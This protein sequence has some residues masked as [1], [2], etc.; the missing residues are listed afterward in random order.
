MKTI[1][2]SFA[3]LGLAIAS[4][5]NS[6]KVTLFQPSIV[7]GQEL[8]PGTYKVEVKDTTAVISKGKQSVEAPIKSEAGDSKFASTTVRY[9][10]DS[11]RRYHHEDRVRQLSPCWRLDRRVTIWAY[12]VSAG[13]GIRVPVRRSIVRR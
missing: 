5:A 1:L 7:A 13:R 11:V 12:E 4:G 9:R 8:Q 6:Y 3:T 2:L 10:R